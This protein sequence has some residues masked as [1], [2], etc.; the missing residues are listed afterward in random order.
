MKQGHMPWTKGGNALARR[1]ARE[2]TRRRCTAAVRRRTT[3]PLRSPHV[4]TACVSP[5]RTSRMLLG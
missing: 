5:A 4:S 3:A 1:H 2:P